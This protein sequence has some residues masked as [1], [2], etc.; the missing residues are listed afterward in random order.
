MNTN[1]LKVALVDPSLFTVPYDAKLANALRSLG[2]QVI[3]YGEARGPEDEPAELVGL[4][5]LFYPEL[6]SHRTQRWPRQ[7][8]RLA[9]G[10]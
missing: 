3:V 2:H 1:Q 10:V 6:L 7:V 8:M 9:K 5:P 4:R